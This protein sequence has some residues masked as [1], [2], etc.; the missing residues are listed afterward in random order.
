MPNNGRFPASALSPIPGGRLEHRAAAAWNAMNKAAGG[1]LRPTGPNSSYRTYAAQQYFW[2]LY[3]TG[4]GNLAA[5]PGT[6]N[7]GKGNAVDLAAPWMASW[8]RAH[9]ARYGWKKVEAPS[10]WWHYNY[11][12]GFKGAAPKPKTYS[13]PGL[14]A[15]GR[16]VAE[17][18]LYHRREM[19][20]QRRTGKGRK[21]RTHLRWARFYRARLVVAWRTSRGAK[22][23]TL[24]RVLKAKSG[25]I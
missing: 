10:E 8:I 2:R 1:G 3:V 19:A 5:R 12:G 17:M 9:G 6:S 24:T 23:A 16:K 25:R 4:R 15:R 14:S 11:V 21:F 18:L 7:H 20:R 13:Y 22:R